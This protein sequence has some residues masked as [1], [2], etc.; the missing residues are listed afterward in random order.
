MRFFD[1]QIFFVQASV[2]S[3]GELATAGS[4]IAMNFEYFGYYVI[5]AFGQTETTFISQNY[6]AKNNKRCRSIFRECML[7]GI[8]FSSAIIIPLTIWCRE[9]S[10]IFTSNQE[11]ISL[12]CDRILIIFI[13]EPM[14]CIY[15]ITAGV[16]RG[17]GR[18][19]LPAVL[20]VIGT[21][22]LRIVWIFTVFR[23]NMT[24][25]GL[26]IA[27]PISWVITSLFM[28]IAYAYIKP[29]RQ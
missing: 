17:T 1:L 18:S 16:L 29:F 14:C 20:T 12:A 25:E 15:E 11:V 26:F 6:G 2:N 28:I 24:L 3:F 10:G 13:V 23:N 9:V 7:L 8:I 5:T 22:M 4:T 21:C 27:F 19:A